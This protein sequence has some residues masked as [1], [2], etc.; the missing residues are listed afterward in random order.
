MGVG[1]PLSLDGYARA[2]DDPLVINLADAPAIGAARGA[3]FIRLEPDGV[4]WPDTGVRGYWGCE[5]FIAVAD[6]PESRPVPSDRR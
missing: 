6:R 1:Q 5:R 4:T 2:I 3:T